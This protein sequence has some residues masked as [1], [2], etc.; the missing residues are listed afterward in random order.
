[1]FDDETYDD[2]SRDNGM[3][4]K[5]MRQELV[6]QHAEGQH[7]TEPVEACWSCEQDAEGIDMASEYNIPATT[8]DGIT[9]YITRGIAPGHFLTAVIENDLLG[10]ISRA[11]TANLEALSRIVSFFY[12]QAPHNCWRSRDNMNK[13][14]KGFEEN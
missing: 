3:S 12:D 7:H 14:I 4:A 1:M 2:L 8:L 6:E 11:D 9:L 5:E 10:A 13:W